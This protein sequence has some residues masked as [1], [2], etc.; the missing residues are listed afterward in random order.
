MDKKVAIAKRRV[1]GVGGV[2]ICFKDKVYY[3]ATN[4]AFDFKIIPKYSGYRFMSDE[5]PTQV[6][7]SPGELKES[8]SIGGEASYVDIEHIVSVF[9][10]KGVLEKIR[11][12]IFR[13]EKDEWASLTFTDRVYSDGRVYQDGSQIMGYLEI[14]LQQNRFDLLLEKIRANKDLDIKCHIRMSQVRGLWT[15]FQH[16]E[17]VEVQNLV[18]FPSF[19]DVHIPEDLKD[20]FEKYQNKDKVFRGGFTL[21]FSEFI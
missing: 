12:T 17:H 7:D 6:G 10:S 15:D 14:Y 5:L 18:Y 8:Q 20:Y 13:T 19:L 16:Y 11:C 21:Y 3:P 4:G 2:E 1:E 9:G